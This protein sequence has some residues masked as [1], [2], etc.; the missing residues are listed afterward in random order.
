MTFSEKVTLQGICIET[1]SHTT[2]HG[3]SSILRSKSR[4][5][6]NCWIIFVF[7]VIASTVWQCS[8]LI[9]SFLQYPSQEKVTLVNS[10]RVKFPA[11]TFCNLNRLRKSLINSK[12]SFLK[13][14]LPFLD[15]SVHGHSNETNSQEALSHDY[16][17]LGYALSRLSPEQQKEVGHQLE[18][19][20]I[21]C[22]FHG[23]ECDK[24]FF[25]S[26]LNHKFGNCYTF[27]SLVQMSNRGQLRRRDVLNATKAGFSYGLT[28]ELF[29]EQEE[30]FQQLSHAAGLRLVIHDQKD[31]PFPED[32]GVNVPP[33]QEAD[34]AIVKLHVHRLKAPYGSNCSNGEEIHNY[35]RDKYKVGYTQEACKKTCGQMYIINNCGCGLWEFPFPKGQNIP[36]CNISNGEIN[37]CVQL[38][39]D[40]FA[41]DELECNCAPQC[42]EEIFELTLSSSQWPSAVYM[43]EFAWKLR[44]S[45]GKLSKAADNIRDNVLK[46]VINY[47]QLNYELI[48][49]APAFQMLKPF[50]P[51]F[52]PRYSHKCRESPMKS[53]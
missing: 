20:L 29:I 33:G 36:F 37:Q 48:E 43:D 19:M 11:V 4:F 44:Q 13:K 53:I 31:M 49:E 26:F 35:Y 24:S 12:Y 30:Y 14:E 21:S 27:N 23:K 47:Q 40:K 5:Q 1:L 16:N 38:Y 50:L 8:E 3:V 22:N 17:R 42:E 41:H 45:G 51:F 10:A 32:D 9:V 6:R 39:E 25:S 28:M 46:V 7:F 34:V 15:D 52:A 2:A 18:D